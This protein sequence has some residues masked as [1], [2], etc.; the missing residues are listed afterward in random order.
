VREPP[1]APPHSAAIVG[2][3][4]RRKC[5]WLTAIWAGLGAATLAV[6][7]WYSSY[8]T[9]VGYEP[10]VPRG[11][12]PLMLL[13]AMAMIPMC[14]LLPPLALSVGRRHLRAVARA[15]SGWIVLWTVTALL[16]I[17]I[18]AVF[19]L[20][21]IRFERLSSPIGSG[22]SMASP[23]WHALEFSAAFL[24]VGLIMAVVLMGATRAARRRSRAAWSN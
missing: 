4:S 9:S 21:L 1:V 15:S 7:F 19:W 2:Y 5:L 16:P 11:L 14:T 8:P 18:E 24:A 12:G 3:A 13:L 23:S 22:V 17:A 20:R 6:V 10:D